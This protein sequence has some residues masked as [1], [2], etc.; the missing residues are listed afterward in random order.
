M[1]AF[2][3]KQAIK[4][5][6]L[7]RVVAHRKADNLI[8]GAWWTGGKGCAV[9]CTLEKYEHKAYE[10]ELGIPEW[11]ARVEDTLYEGMSLKASKTF[12]EKFLKAI[13][14][15]ANLEK[16]KSK[17]LIYVISGTLKNFDNKK[18]PRIVSAIKEIIKLHR[19]NSVSSEE[20][21]AARESAY[22]AAAQAAAYS[23]A[24]SA[25]AAAW[26]TYSAA[27]SAYSAAWSAYSAEAAWAAAEARS[28]EA[29]SAA[30]DRCAT[31]LLKLLRSAK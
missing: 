17:F 6:Y 23:A 31:Q 11:L 30:Y 20:W 3:G 13:R 8:R 12:P 24:S 2:H 21:L 16:I 14:P 29:R 1:K 27:W 18:Y 26:S 22:S 19:R 5:K 15:G 10:T 4:T 7:N 9:G 25:R 28:T